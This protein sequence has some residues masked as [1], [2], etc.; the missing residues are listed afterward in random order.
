MYPYGG[1]QSNTSQV[2]VNNPN[3][4]LHP[5]FAAA[6]EQCL[7][8]D[9]DEGDTLYVPLKWWHHCTSLTTSFSVNIWWL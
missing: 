2:D 9:L 5:K 3:I 4:E 6:A 1:V 7:T 8:I